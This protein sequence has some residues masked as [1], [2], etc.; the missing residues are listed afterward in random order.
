MHKNKGVLKNKPKKGKGKE[1]LAWRKTN[2]QKY[3]KT[4]KSIK[5]QGDVQKNQNFFSPVADREEKMRNQMKNDP[6]KKKTVVH[7]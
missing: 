3:K 2:T 5:G 7:L 6:Q 1:T 4:Y